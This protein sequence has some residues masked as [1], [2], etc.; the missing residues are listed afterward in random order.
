MR[1]D[2]DVDVDVADLDD[3]VLFMLVFLLVFRL[4]VF[5]V[6]LVVR[7]GSTAS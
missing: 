3:R 4:V 1:R 7:S 6:V 5:L 2:T